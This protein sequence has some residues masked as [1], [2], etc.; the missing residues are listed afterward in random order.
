MIDRRSCLSAFLLAAMPMP[1]LAVEPADNLNDELDPIRSKYGLPALAAAVVKEGAIVAS[2]AVGV[3]VH[4]TDIK[5]TIDDRFD[6]GS[7]TK[8]M[9]ATLAGMAT[10]A[11]SIGLRRSAMCSAWRC[12]VS[13][14]TLPP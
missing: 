7:D 3:R 9:T 2:G 11:S 8:A 13:I 12:R 6:L 4:G 5:V 1:S 14:R 10:K